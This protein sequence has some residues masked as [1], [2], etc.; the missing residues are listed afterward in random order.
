MFYLSQRTVTG[1]ISDAFMHD[2]VSRNMQK[3]IFSHHTLF[4]TYFILYFRH[5][6]SQDAAAARAELDRKSIE[7]EQH[8]VAVGNLHALL[9][10]L[11][12]QQQQQQQQAQQQ[13]QQAESAQV[14]ECRASQD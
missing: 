3:Q 14:C 11:Q 2:R 10:K 5:L 12:E 13:Q 6:A 1:R 9:E 7:C 4:S 8:I